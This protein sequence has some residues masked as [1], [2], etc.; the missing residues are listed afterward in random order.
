MTKDDLCRQIVSSSREWRRAARGK[1]VEVE[2]SANELSDLLVQQQERLK[3]DWALVACN[4]TRQGISYR[5]TSVAL[6]LQELAPFVER[7][8][9]QFFLWS[10]SI[11]P[12]LASYLPRGQSE[13][14][15][16]LCGLVNIQCG[17]RTRRGVAKTALSIVD[18]I[19]SSDSGEVRNH[20]EYAKI[21]RTIRL[22]VQ[23]YLKRRDS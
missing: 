20:A 23:E 9:W 11:T 22:A 18:K 21:Y 13:S 10:P 3:A 6:T 19:Q 5:R 1:A 12:V 15:L 7:G 8:Y 17:R 2:L 4:R 16:S 14:T